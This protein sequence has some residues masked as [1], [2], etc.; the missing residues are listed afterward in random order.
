MWPPLRIAI[1]Q[2]CYL[3]WKGYFDLI[4]TSDCFI[5]LDNVQYSRGD[6]R[7]RNQIKTEKGLKW[8]TLPLRHSGTFPSLIEDMRI[9]DPDWRKRHRSQIEQAYR[10]APHWPVLRNWLDN[11]LM[12]QDSDSLSVVNE[13]LTRSLASLLGIQTPIV[14]AQSFG[15]TSDEP[16]ERVLE[17]CQRAG[18]TTYVSGPAAKAY[19]REDIFA[20]AAIKVEYFDYSGYPVYP[21]LHGT[22]VH[23]VS[24]VDTIAHLGHAASQ[25][26]NR[27]P[28]PTS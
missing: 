19:L 14:L 17:L 25:A 13:N 11:V 22:F 18:A 10:H 24:I 21:Q 4:R 26:L 2:S 3:P 1:V 6:W 20:K 28:V 15:K 7:N 5:L 9:S 12:R 23:A 8:L 16:S 27:P